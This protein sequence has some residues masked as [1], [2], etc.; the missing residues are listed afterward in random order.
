[1]SARSSKR[2]A[3]S[4]PVEASRK[5]VDA[6]F[7]EALFARAVELARQYQ[8]LIVP[9][10]DVVFFGRTLEMPLAMSDGPT[11]EKC[12][13]NTIEATACAIATMLENG[14]T[15]PAPAREGKRDTQVNIRLSVEERFRLEQAA[16]N[17][18]YR[19]LSD[20]IRAAAIKFAS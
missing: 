16:S 13:E 4:K 19:S 1:M 8:L 10:E 11:V 7:D 12:A 9:D 14:Q 18:G 6:P 2:S 3:G 15:P 20:Y 5:P 17:A